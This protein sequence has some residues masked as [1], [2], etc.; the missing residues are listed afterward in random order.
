MAQVLTPT[1]GKYTFPA[2]LGHIPVTLRSS[3]MLL[4]HAKP[5]YTIYETRQEPFSL[6]VSLAADG[7]AGGTAYVDDGESVGSAIKVIY[8]R[9]EGGKISAT[10]EGDYNVEQPLSEVTVLGV[11]QKPERVSFGGVETTDF[12]YDEGLQ[13]LVVKGLSGDLNSG[14]E[15]FF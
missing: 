1:D 12:T 9:A 2:P 11:A 4:L 7:T 3:S 14:W 15:L 13:K 6:L 5:S 10:T 8:L